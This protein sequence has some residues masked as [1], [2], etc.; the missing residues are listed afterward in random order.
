MGAALT[1]YR[2]VANIVGAV[3]IVLVVVGMP[4]KYVWHNPVVVETIGPAHGF[5]YMVF[6][7]TAFDLGRR[8]HWPLGRMVLVM[9]AG[10]IPFVSFYAERMVTRQVRQ[11]DPQPVAG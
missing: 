1:R 2:V 4:L 10:T 5:L 8:A 9:L 7:L 6:L 11:P 3:L